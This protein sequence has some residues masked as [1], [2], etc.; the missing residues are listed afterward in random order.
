MSLDRLGT[1]YRAEIGEAVDTLSDLSEGQRMELA[2]F[3]YGRA[4]LRSLGMAIAATCDATRLTRR[5]GALGQV[6]ATQCREPRIPRAKIT[7]AGTRH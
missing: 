5:A 7:L 4:H 6:L 3:C 1:L 2:F